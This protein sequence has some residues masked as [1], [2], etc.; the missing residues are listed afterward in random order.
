[1]VLLKL[2]SELA[3]GTPEDFITRF[4]PSIDISDGEYEISLASVSLYYSWYNISATIGNNLISYNNGVA[5]FPKTIPNGNYTL[6][7]LNDWLHSEMY[8]DGNYTVV[9]GINTYDISIYADAPT[10]TV[11]ISISG[12]YTLDLTQSTINELLGWDPVVVAISGNGSKHANI[13]LGVT[14]LAIHCDIASQSY[15]GGIAGNVLH[16]FRPN[17]GPGGSIGSTPNYPI[18]LPVNAYSI[19]S[20]RIRF[21]DQAGNSLPLNGEPLTCDLQLRKIKK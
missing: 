16:S 19:N 17:N 20:I 5:D 18:W 2:N 11:G 1:M 7:Q 3:D 14:D 9:G 15:S 13:N 4:T 21:T 8:K 6:S 12:G 10:L